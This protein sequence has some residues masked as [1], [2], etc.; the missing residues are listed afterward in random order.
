M[1]DD[2]KD[3]DFDDNAAAAAAAAG[4][5]GGGDGGE[6]E[7]D[8]TSKM[9]TDNSFLNPSHWLL[10]RTNHYIA[11]PT[12]SPCCRQ[13]VLLVSQRANFS[14]D[15]HWK[16]RLYAVAVGIPVR[17]I[18]MDNAGILGARPGRMPDGLLLQR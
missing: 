13:T 14:W 18:H 15:R 12:F 6:K 16:I 3:F 1:D 2:D 8:K 5:G 7:R 11:F 9:T 17:R 10:P 4:G